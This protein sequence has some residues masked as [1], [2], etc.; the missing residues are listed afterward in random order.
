MR[1]DQNLS[2]SFRSIISKS[3]HN[4]VNQFYEQLGLHW[5]PGPSV[6]RAFDDQSYMAMLVQCKFD[7]NYYLALHI[8]IIRE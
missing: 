7:N 3:R 4:G 1:I 6:T 8:L 5:G 2:S